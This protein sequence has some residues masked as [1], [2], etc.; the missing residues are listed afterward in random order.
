MLVTM[1][2]YTSKGLYH[3]QTRAYILC[4][5]TA[6]NSWFTMNGHARASE[7]WYAYDDTVLAPKGSGSMKRVGTSRVE[8]SV[9]IRILLLMGPSWAQAYELPYT[10]SHIHVYSSAAC[11]R[12]LSAAAHSAAAARAAAD[13][14]AAIRDAGLS[15]GLYDTCVAVVWT[16][17]MYSFRRL[18]WIKHL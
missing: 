11:L 12:L 2:T 3:V 8:R 4:S 1:C 18:I 16:P 13:A 6:S 17:L 14:V 15:A 10:G 5:N 9:V 7:A